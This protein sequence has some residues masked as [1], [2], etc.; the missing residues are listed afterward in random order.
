MDWAKG[1]AG[2][3]LAVALAIGGYVGF[4]ALS[5]QPDGI[6]DGF[7]YAVDSSYDAL[8]YAEALRLKEAGVVLYIQALTAY[9]QSGLHQPAS[10]V[11]SLR[12]ARDAGLAIAGYALVGDPHFS[13]RESMDFARAGVPG[14]L[15]DAL[16]F[17]AVD[18]EVPGYPVVEIN[19]ALLRTQELG[20]PMVVYTNYNSWVNYYGDPPRLPGSL[21]WN[22]SWDDHPDFDYV[23][24]PFGGWPS[25]EV[26]GEQWSGGAYVA[27]Q[28]VDRDVFRALIAPPSTPILPLPTPDSPTLEER[29]A[30]LERVILNRYSPDGRVCDE[31]RGTDYRSD[32]E[33]SWFLSHCLN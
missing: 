31:M 14:D 20:K 1:L 10:R 11:S 26:I 15:W 4:G 28:Y 12:N 13:G 25:T 3:A 21:L 29:V 33:R 9:P 6:P 16:L 17:V 24:R 23:R 8:T 27:G 22:A 18:V 5:G 32:V 2:A 30:V 19:Y 7:V